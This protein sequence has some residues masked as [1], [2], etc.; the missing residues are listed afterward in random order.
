MG[1]FSFYIHVYYQSTV[2]IHI[3]TGV[4]MGCI[5]MLGVEFNRT[6]RIFQWYDYGQ[7]HQAGGFIYEESKQHRCGIRNF[8]DDM[9]IQAMWFH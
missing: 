6:I 7:V 8:Y 4:T 3:E 5:Y 9:N 2:L 1:G